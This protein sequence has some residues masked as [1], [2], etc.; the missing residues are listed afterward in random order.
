MFF[1][2][3]MLIY[4]EGEFHLKNAITLH[5]YPYSV[6]ITYHGAYEDFFGRT[7]HHE[8]PKRPSCNPFPALN[9]KSP[10]QGPRSCRIGSLP[11][12]SS[13]SALSHLCLLLF[14]PFLQFDR[15]I[16]ASEVTLVPKSFIGFSPRI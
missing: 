2:E 6:R 1:L 5:I 11:F 7:N 16:K 9:K 15:P 14:L 13:L 8:G 12:S 10:A 3:K 4:N